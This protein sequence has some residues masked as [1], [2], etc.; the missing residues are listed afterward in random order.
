MFNGLVI[1]PGYAGSNNV[2]N[3]T[4]TH[5][6][7]WTGFEGAPKTTAVSVHTPLRKKQLN[8][9]L[10]FMSEKYGVTQK[11]IFNAYFAY[12]ISFKNSSLSFGV[13]GG[14]DITRNYWSDVQTTTAGD[15]VFNNNREKDISPVAGAGVYYLTKKYFVGLSSPML[16]RAGNSSKEFKPYILNGGFIINLSNDLKLK[17]SFLVKYISHSP[18]QADLNINAYYKSFGLGFSYRSN[19]A[20]VFILNYSVND[21]FSVGYSY[22]LTISRLSTFNNGS[23]E[24]ML[25]YEFGYKLNAPGPRYF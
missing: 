16:L 6:N 2:L 15:V 19:D 17:P 9:G 1:N 10:G 23:H 22:D 3:A 7:Q 24:I 14:M 25:K 18:V 8:V 20:V 4:I 11:N 21:Q 5:R 13:S 12:K